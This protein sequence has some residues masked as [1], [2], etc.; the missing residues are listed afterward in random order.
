MIDLI[1]Q[2]RSLLLTLVIVLGAG[3]IAGAGPAAFLIAAGV[4][5]CV[6]WGAYA[7]YPRALRRYLILDPETPDVKNLTAALGAVLE[8]ALNAQ[9]SVILRI[10]AFTADPRFHPRLNLT[11]KGEIEVSGYPRRQRLPHPGVWLADHPLPFDLPLTRSFTLVF[12]PCPGARVRVTDN[13]PPPPSPYVWA[14]VVLIITLACLFSCN[15]LLA[16]VLA[17]SGETYLLRRYP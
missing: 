5:C 13:T 17:F 7:R 11:P 10:A 3:S 15:N 2:T 1:K 12:S 16:A 4:A 14:A 9:K 6:R 8:E